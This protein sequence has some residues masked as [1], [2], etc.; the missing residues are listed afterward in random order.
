MLKK[1]DYFHS[2]LVPSKIS[3]LTC[4]YQ[5]FYDIR[6]VVVAF[7]G[8]GLHKTRPT[9]QRKIYQI[10]FARGGNGRKKENQIIVS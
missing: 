2:C 1:I 8:T 9:R 7:Q 3:L 4:K 5:E 6:V 10:A